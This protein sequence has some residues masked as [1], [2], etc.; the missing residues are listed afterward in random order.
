MSFAHL[1]KHQTNVLKQKKGKCIFLHVNFQFYSCWL[2]IH[3]FYSTI[4]TKLWLFPVPSRTADR[5]DLLKKKSNFW[6]FWA[7]D[8]FCKRLLFNFNTDPTRLLSRSQHVF[9]WYDS[10]SPQ[11]E[12]FCVLLHFD[13]D[14]LLAL[15][16]VWI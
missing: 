10:H 14:I 9:L 15:F 7:P 5:N 11:W 1:A 12:L 3:L 13:R 16:S 8:L 4:L 2:V 6:P